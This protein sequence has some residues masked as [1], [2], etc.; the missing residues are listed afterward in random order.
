MRPRSSLKD[1]NH[2]LGRAAVRSVFL[3]LGGVLDSSLVGHDVE[4][5]V[6]A[7][8]EVLDDVRGEHDVVLDDLLDVADALHLLEEVPDLA[9]DL[10]HVVHLLH[11]GAHSV[12]GF[13][14]DSVALGLEVLDELKEVV[15]LISQLV[16]LRLV[17]VDRLVEAANLIL[18]M[19]DSGRVF[20]ALIVKMVPLLLDVVE[21]L[22]EA[23]ALGFNMPELVSRQMLDE[24]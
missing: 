4:M 15:R 23:V 21:F 3:L 5:H 2:L 17:V 16:A 10:G 14:A 24:R 12:V 1:F 7:L 20:F 13:L 19:M 9:L 18:E 6:A 11:E 8:L 22:L